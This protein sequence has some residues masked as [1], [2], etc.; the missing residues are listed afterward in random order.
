MML[1]FPIMLTGQ[2]VCDVENI[3]FSRQ[4][5]L[6]SFPI[7]FP[8]CEEIGDIR[9][10]G[11][12]IVNL[13]G[14]KNLKRI[15]T[16]RIQSSNIDDLSILDE[17][18]DIE[19]FVF[20]NN[21]YIKKI[22]F[23]KNL[24]I[25]GTLSIIGCDSLIEINNTNIF[26]LKNLNIGANKTLTNISGLK[27]SISKTCFIYE[28]HGDSFFLN[29]KIDTCLNL[30]IS[31]INSIEGLG[32]MDVNNVD[33]HRSQLTKIDELSKIKNLNSLI[34]I[35]NTNLSNCSIEKIC[36]NLDNP[37]FYLGVNMNAQGCNTIDEIRAGCLS[38]STNQFGANIIRIYPNP[39]ITDIHIES[40]IELS[41]YQ[42]YNAYGD[43][44][45]Q[46]QF[47]PQ[48][49]LSHLQSGLYILKLY[50]LNKELVN[51]SKLIKIE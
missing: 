50:G 16:L 26:S 13:N 38:N 24:N 33:I 14:L 30:T 46:A 27:V 47:S 23:H 2:N 43:L 44:V 19:S 6:D 32:R 5:Q 28:I 49:Q 7:L 17:V 45:S 8:E 40:K 51:T 1:L 11:S 12:D 3:V 35:L 29:H 22:N 36:K 15:K 42:L 31:G 20:S 34:M 21:D 41:Y 18:E 9:I 4:S 39:F 48:L 25:R 37:Y 10:F